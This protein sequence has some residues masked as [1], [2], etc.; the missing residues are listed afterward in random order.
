M[1]SRVLLNGPARV[2]EYKC[3]AGPAD[4]PF[5]EQHRGFSLSYVRAGSFGYRAC[6]RAYELVAGSIMVGR[7]GDEYVCAHEHVTGDEC[8]SFHYDESVLEMIDGVARAW[9]T[10]ALPPLAELLVLGELAQSSAADSSDVGLDE[11]AL[12]LASRFVRV[13]S[14]ACDH[15]PV[16]SRRDRGRAVDTALWLDEHS[17]E[18]IDLESAAAQAGLS[19][20]HFLR[21]FANALGVTPHQFLMRSRLRH[22]AQLLADDSRSITD[23]AYDVGF[24]DLSNFVRTFHRAA[25]VSPRD[26]RKAARGERKMLSERLA[27][28]PAM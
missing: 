22:A 8:L 5:V 14:D 28:P 27:A 26:F 11:V 4:K 18:P 9:R 3:E 16:L 12:M 15:N 2:L 19:E 20:F 7:P 25:G 17:S 6:G 10:T 24:C 21:T 23:I 13:V 1:Q